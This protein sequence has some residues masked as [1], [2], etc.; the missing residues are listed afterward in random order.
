MKKLFLVFLMSISSLL[1]GQDMTLQTLKNKSIHIVD[2]D[3]NLL[4]QDKGYRKKKVL[5]FFFGTRCPYCEKEI[6]QIV[7]M[8]SNSG[9]HVIGVQAQFPVSDRTLKKFIEKK[10]INFDVLSSKSG[11]RLVRYLQK[12]RLWVGGVPFYV[13][14]DKFGNLEPLEITEVFEKL[15]KH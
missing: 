14:S 12:R 9:L 7:Q 3:G 6:P 13:L 15:K 11:N 1:F 4:F 5:F 8:V 10:R 2:F